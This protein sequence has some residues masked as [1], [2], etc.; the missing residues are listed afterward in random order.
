MSKPLSGHYNNTTGTKNF[1]K[2]IM[3]NSSARAIIALKNPHFDSREHST[4]Y[5]QLSSKKLKEYKQKELNRTLTNEEYKR[6][7]FHKRLSKRR[8]LG[9]NR[10]WD[11]EFHRVKNNL[12]TTRNWDEVQ[13]SAILRHKRPKFNG[14]TLHSH[15]TYS[16]AKYPHLAN[17][18]SLIYPATR[19]EHVSGWHGSNTR[20]SLSG[21]PIKDF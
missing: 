15:H 16:V 13:K 6:L 21:K 4:K 5:K 2:Q 11:E 3:A 8:Q 7:E 17:H 18:G 9:I 14:E 20:N 12:P 10:F 1:A 19:N